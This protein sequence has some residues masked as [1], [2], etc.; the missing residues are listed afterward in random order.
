MSKVNKDKPKILSENLFPVV[1]VGASAGGLDAFKKL[2]KAIPPKT[3]MAYILVQHLHPDHISSLPEILQRET[4]M[5]VNEISDNVKVKPDEV[6][7]IPAN[8]MLVAT[9][10]VLL[11]SPRPSKDHKNMPIDLFFSS[12]AEVHQNHA[13][14]IVLSG[15]GID[16]TSGLKN[17]KDH[18]GLTFAQNLDT[19]AF[20]SMPRSAIEAEVVDFI[21]AP[22]EMPRQLLELGRTINTM[23]LNDTSTPSQATERESFARLL[24]LLR[25]RKSVDFSY[26]KQT[27]I[28]RRILRRLAILKLE[29]ITEYLVYIQEN[30]PELDILFQDL[31]IPVT[32]FFR[33]PKVFENLCETVFPEFVKN[34]S[35]GNPLRIWIAGCSTGEEAYSMGMCLHEFLSD[36]ISTIK[37]QIFA[38]DISEKSIAKARSGVYN[39]KEVEGI[40]D[41]R[42]QEFFTKTNEQYTLKKTIR[43]MCVFAIHNFLKD[44]PF[45]KIDL[46]SCRN[47]LIYMEPFLQKKAMNTFHYALNE[48]GYLL[49]GKAETTGGSAELFLP[50]G[51]KEKMYVK[52]DVPGRFVN[53]ASE[54]REENLKD[55]DYALRSNQRRKDDFQKDADDILLSQ[56]TPASVIVNDQLDIVQFRGSTGDFLEPSPGRASLNV[57]KM[58]RDG[59]SFELRNAL[60]KSKKTNK[61]FSKEGIQ[62]NNGKSLVTIEVI[63]LKDTIDPHF[64]VLFRNVVPVAAKITA[65]KGVLKSTDL[66]NSPGNI[67]I[68]NLEKDLLHS[69]EDMRSITEDQE[70][71]NEELQSANEE[72]LSGSEELQSLNEEL[73]TSKEELQSTNEELITVN[74]E[75]F[76]RNE[77]YNEARMYAEAIVSTIHEP[78]LVIS[79]D[80]SIKSANQSFYK[81]FSITEQDTIGKN[82]FELQNNGWNIPDLESQL[83]RVQKGKE[84]FLEWETRYAFPLAG[85]RSI[86]FNA[87]PVQNENGEHLILLAFNDIT[88]RRKIEE[89]EKKNTEDLKKIL[90]NIPQITSTASAEGSVTYVNKFFL[91]YS[92]LTLDE[93]LTQGWESVVKP[94]MLEKV[95][96]TWGASIETGKDFMMEILFKRKSDNMYRWHISRATALLNDNGKVISWVGSATDIHNQKIKEEVKDEFISIAS[97]ELKTPLTTAKAYIQLLHASMIKS[98]Y[99]DLL[100]IEKAELSIERLNDLIAELLDV[101][102]IQNGKLNLFVTVFDFNKMLEDAIQDVQLISHHHRIIKTGEVNHDVSADKERLKQVIINLLNNAV[103]YSPKA[104]EIIVHVV[105]KEG[106]VTVSVKDSGIGIRK[107]NLTKIFDRYYREEERAFHFQGLGIGLAIAHDIIQRHNGKIWAESEAGNGST[108]YFTIPI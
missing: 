34:K 35:L 72:L 85:T 45:A 43:D 97:H 15:N 75:L 76:D 28:H 39:K 89:V 68:R 21:L 77:Q 55:K 86:C 94:E 66:K 31:L 64:L 60:Q 106:E 81:N 96:K 53:I 41:I 24:S 38:T 88:A 51:K 30:K 44:P 87:Q 65:G 67:R 80:F 22:E 1:G 29:T 46:L 74:Q 4:K 63:P 48:K 107:E 93:A 26:Y 99:K 17:I 83:L 12:L 57:L 50:F 20:D 58:A 3:G 105:Q 40:S 11:L 78:L 59:L 9:D 52:K 102:K 79:K 32:S 108:F 101:S 61:P 27:T 56:Y 82:L 33:D 47:V 54:R 90:E 69:R 37:I 103:K 5:P 95:K 104:N 84:K 8:K 62:L 42:L 49:L 18:G 25:S 36:K 7:I 98:N 10:G 6:Y 2:I 23:P 91:D 73:E 92:G 71:A 19:A 16:G 70:A 14:G 100:F 13:I